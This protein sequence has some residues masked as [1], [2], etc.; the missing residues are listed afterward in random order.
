MFKKFKTKE[1]VFIALMGALSFILAISLGTLLTVITGIPLMGGMI[2]NWL[3]AYLFILT[4]LVVKKFGVV[5]LTL[6]IYS[7]LSIPTNNF[8][9]PG[10]YKLIIGIS[11]GLLLDIILYSGK[12]KKWTYYFGA[13]LGFLIVMHYLYLLLKLLEITLDHRITPFV[14]IFMSVYCIQGLLGAW[15]ARLTYRRIKDKRIIKQIED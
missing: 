1:L 15:L 10:I 6:F 13:A 14:I 4:A 2:L 5:T 12:Y 9:P 7:V 8:G 3:I 11:L